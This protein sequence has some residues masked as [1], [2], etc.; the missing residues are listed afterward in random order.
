MVESGQSAIGPIPA[1]RQCAPIPDIRALPA[2]AR[3]RTSSDAPPIVMANVRLWL[4]RG[5]SQL[6]QHQ[7]AVGIT[8]QSASLPSPTYAVW[9]Q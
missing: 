8:F 2:I 3:K 7:L 6:L 4:E 1:S 5:H 9:R